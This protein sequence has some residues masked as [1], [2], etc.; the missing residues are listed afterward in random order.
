MGCRKCR[1]VAKTQS[2][3]RDF[4]SKWQISL[5]SYFFIVSIGFSNGFMVNYGW[6]LFEHVTDART[7]SLGK[8]TTAYN[9][10]SPTSSLI[11]PIFS[12]V[13][14]PNVNLT[15]Q[16]RFS[17]ILN[18]DLAGFQ[19]QR[20]GKPIQVNMLPFFKKP[21]SLKKPKKFYRPTNKLLIIYSK[22]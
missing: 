6:E 13:T 17:G 2:L 10:G 18:N 16:S 12:L 4:V 8:A 5:F 20:K 7:A 15:H 22:E 21:I 3:I 14:I 1:K 19:F 11:N 9:F